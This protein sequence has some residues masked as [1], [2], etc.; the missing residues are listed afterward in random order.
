MRLQI[1]REY[2]GAVSQTQKPNLL[3]RGA[4]TVKDHYETYQEEAKHYGMPSTRDPE[5][6]CMCPSCYNQRMWIEWK[7]IQKPQNPDVIKEIKSRLSLLQVSEYY[8]LELFGGGR[9]R[10]VRCVS[11][12]HEDKDPSMCIDTKNN[13]FRCFSSSCGVAGDVIDFLSLLEGKD[14]Q[15]S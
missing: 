7:R 15:E 4:E 9:Y 5:F 1:R 6:Y 10:K 12:A 14:G 11:P 8:K 3:F 2:S 13:T